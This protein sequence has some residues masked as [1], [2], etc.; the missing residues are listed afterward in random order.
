[1]MEASRGVKTEFLAVAASFKKSVISILPSFAF[2]TAL[3]IVFST[4][5]SSRI[6]AVSEVLTEDVLL[7]KAKTSEYEILC[8]GVINDKVGNRWMTES[9]SL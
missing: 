6:T 3:W 4:A 5:S 2:L 7:W 9:D 8:P 1:M